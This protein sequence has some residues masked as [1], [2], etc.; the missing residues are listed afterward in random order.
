MVFN[1]CMKYLLYL[2]DGFVKKHPITQAEF[3]L[4][5]G[6]DCDLVINE[7]FVSREHA[8]LQL[9][10]DQLHISDC[11]STNGIYLGQSRLESAVIELN[12]VFRIGQMDF[13]FKQG[14][15]SEFQVSAHTRRVLRRLS[16]LKSDPDDTRQSLSLFDRTLVHTLEW[17]FRISDMRD[18]LHKARDPLFL[19]LQKGFIFL[20]QPGSSRALETIAF[21]DLGGVKTPDIRELKPHLP[22]LWENE[23]IGEKLGRR[24]RIYAFPLEADNQCRSLVYLLPRNNELEFRTIDFLRDFSRELGLIFLF[25]EKNQSESRDENPKSPIITRDPGMMRILEQC[26]KVAQNNLAVLV[27]GETGT[28]KELIARFIHEHSP[29]CRHRYVAINCSAIPENLLEDELFGHEKGAFTDARSR[30]TGKLELASGGTLLLDEIGDMPLSLQAKLLRVL[31]ENE[32]YRLGGNDPILVNLRVVSLTNQDIQ[33][34]LDSGRFRRDLYYRIAHFTVHL[35]PLRQRPDDIM[36]LFNHFLDAFMEET[37]VQ[38]KGVS[39]E[40]AEILKHYLWPGNVRQVEST[41]RLLAS[42]A[43]TGDLITPDLLGPE[44]N[45]GDQE[46]TRM[47]AAAGAND[48]KSRLIALLEKHHWNKTRVAAALGISRTALYKRMQKFGVQYKAKT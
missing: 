38:I 40:T 2:Q 3:T 5:R 24:F 41:A 46:L 9:K 4:G 8:R 39:N 10:D 45:S 17:G 48:E 29:R 28:G 11:G 34:L 20:L 21:L 32:L 19:T 25:N 42:I 37:D 35:P 31:Q 44:F 15:P 6:P 27:S 7:P 22:A 12:G 13:F 16:K 33:S 30:R 23:I 18:I 1:L 47:K 26:R 14:N 43:T 36:P